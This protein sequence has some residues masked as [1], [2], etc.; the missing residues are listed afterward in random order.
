MENRGEYNSGKVY[1]IDGIVSFSNLHNTG[2][3]N[4]R[5]AA[6]NSNSSSHKERARTDS[7]KSFMFTDGE[8]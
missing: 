7:H 8:C 2:K 1:T 4:N 5:S 6:S 3:K